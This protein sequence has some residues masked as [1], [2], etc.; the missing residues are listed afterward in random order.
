MVYSLK[1]DSHIDDMINIYQKYHPNITVERQIGMEEGKGTS[2]KDAVAALNTSLMSGASPDVLFLDG[3]D[4][5]KYE[6]IVV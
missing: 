1:E 3:L 2:I 6:K 5:E 4:V